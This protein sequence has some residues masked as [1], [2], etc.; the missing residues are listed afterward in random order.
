MSRLLQPADFGIVAM[1]APAAAFVGLFLD[2]G[3]TQAT[4]Q[5]K[6]ITHADVNALFWINAAV[7]LLLAGV[8]VAISPLVA[9]FYNAPR[10]QPLV[11]AISLQLI[12]SGL[13]AQHYALLSRR[14]AFGRLA[15]LESIAAVAGLAAALTWAVVER[16]F[17]AL[18]LGGMVTAIIMSAGCWMMS[19][20]RP[21]MPRWVSGARSMV[22]LGAGITGFNFFHYIHRNFDQ[23]L[24]GRRWGEV[25]LGLYDRAY[26]LLLFPFQQIINPIARVMVP[27][28]SRLNDEPDRYRAAYLKVV[29]ILLLISLPGVAVATAAADI[30]I[31]LA[32]GQKWVGAVPIFQALGFAGLLQP[33][34]TPSNWLFISQGRSME[35]MRWGMFGAAS[36]AAAFLI[37][38]PYGAFGVAVAYAISEYL[39]TP[40]LWLYLGRRG[41]ISAG[42]MLKAGLPMV[43]AAHAAVAMIWAIRPFMPTDGFATLG[44]LLVASYSLCI[45]ILALFPSGRITL[46]EMRRLTRRLPI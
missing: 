11:A 28:L 31:P 29:P 25:E 16:S 20:W 12:V 32:L 24:I 42:Q 2:L 41:P 22:H 36:S 5:K 34:N 23:I 44:L 39:R 45:A 6:N 10:V 8:M 30:L 3:L 13:G 19:G 9:W 21:S 46:R 26:R 4:E 7:S 14:M 1:A 35:F 17:W 43:L 33:L 37:G 38:L 27:A 15:I 40:L 18:F